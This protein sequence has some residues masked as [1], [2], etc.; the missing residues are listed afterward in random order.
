MDI[1]GEKIREA[2]IFNNLSITDLA[3]KVSVSKQAISQ[4]ENN[5]STPKNEVLFNIVRT[6]NFP[7][8]YFIKDYT[9]SIKIGNVFFRAMAKST[10]LD[11]ESYK[12]RAMYVTMFYTYLCEYLDMP[13]L[14]ETVI[15][16][17][18]IDFDDSSIF[19]TI[20]Y[21]LREKWGLG[22]R[23]VENVMNLLESKG[24]I[25]STI[26]N[27]SKNVDGFTQVG[28]IFGK[29]L[30]CVMIEDNKGSMA[31]MNFSAA[32]ELGH[33]I[34]HKNLYLQE[35]D[36]VQKALLEQQAND[37]AAS[38][39]LPKRAIYADLIDPLSLKSYELLK[40]KWRVSIGALLRRALSV[41]RINNYQYTKLIKSYSYRGY[42]KN[43]PL[44]D[45]IPIGKPILFKQSLELLL[46][47]KV[48][49][50]NSM[51]REL[52]G[53]GLAMNMSTLVDLLSLD[54]T[55]FNRYIPNKPITFAP[56]IKKL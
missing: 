52:E 14:D 45:I 7:L 26:A 53:F 31:R 37:F 1:I 25:V 21:E 29:K 38:F 44:D 40:K 11:K 36:K 10:N 46:D 2:R 43:E 50:I 19:D 33:I 47:E 41:G 20:S 4:Y 48:I 55:F 35:M 30:Y 3:D 32:H 15:G 24:I 8:E 39:L 6:L 17:K 18:D 54:K 5:I 23:P 28:E 49:S 34:L 27:S 12:M 16:T 51:L 42:R 13:M 22:E 9:S 56:R